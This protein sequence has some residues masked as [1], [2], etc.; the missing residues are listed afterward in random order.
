M[1]MTRC[2]KLFRENCS[3]VLDAHKNLV[4]QEEI[5]AKKDFLYLKP[6]EIWDLKW[7]MMMESL[8]GLH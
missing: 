2:S 8:L 7:N 5:P 1:E 6:R 4:I 3:I